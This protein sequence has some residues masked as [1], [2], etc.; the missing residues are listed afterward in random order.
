M[1][2]S[3]TQWR[4]SSA[5]VRPPIAIEIS[6]WPEVDV[7]LADH[8]ELAHTRATTAAASEQDAA[9]GLDVEEPLDRLRDGAGEEPVAAQPRGGVG[10]GRHGGGSS[11]SAGRHAD[12]ASR[13]TSAHRRRD[14]VGVV[15]GRRR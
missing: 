1:R 11:G 8:G 6:V 3:L 7:G 13:L 5:T 9:R 2:P 12:Q 4:R 14:V 10:A 15:E